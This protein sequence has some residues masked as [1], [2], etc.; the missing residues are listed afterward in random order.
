MKGTSDTVEKGIETRAWGWKPPS[1]V[2]SPQRHEVPPTG[3]RREFTPIDLGPRV[4]LHQGLPIP[5]GQRQEDPSSG[6]TARRA[7]GEVQGVMA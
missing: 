7:G 2:W 1:W 5:W 4:L 6:K 3:A